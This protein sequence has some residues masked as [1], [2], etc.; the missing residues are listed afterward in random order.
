MDLE[1]VVQNEV[2]KKVKNKYYTSMHICGIQKNGA[3][4]PLSGA[5]TEMKTERV[6]TWMQMRGGG[7]VR[8]E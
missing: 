1:P 4:K 5:G 3:D 6:N 2:N 7:K 8:L